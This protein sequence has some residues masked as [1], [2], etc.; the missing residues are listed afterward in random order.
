VGFQYLLGGTC[1]KYTWSCSQAG[2][3][4]AHW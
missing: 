1:D 4:S 3:E 2:R